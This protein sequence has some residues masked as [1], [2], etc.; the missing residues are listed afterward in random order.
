MQPNDRGK[1]SFLQG[2]VAGVLALALLFAAAPAVMAQ[3]RPPGARTGAD[4]PA[5]SPPPQEPDVPAKLNLAVG[6]LVTVRTTSWL[7]SDHNKQGETFTAIL[8]QPLIID[9]W[10]VARRGQTVVGQVTVSDKGGRVKGTSQ[11]GVEL[12]ELT[13]V[14][15]QQLPVR[16][17][18]LKMTSSTSHGQDVA[19]VVGTTA[20]GA[21]IG[22]AADW[23]RG[24]GIGAGVGAAAGI[25]G[26]L[27]TRGR[28]AVIPAESVL[29]FR[30][31]DPVTISTERSQFAFRP[32]SDSDYGRGN[33]RY[34]RHAPIY[35][36]PYSPYCSYCAPYPY[37]YYP[38]Y[39]Y[40]GPAFVGVF[41]FRGHRRF[42]SW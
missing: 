12:T 34:A 41:G 33:G 13:L 14:D 35:S 18:F 20:L 15:G 30:M 4:R 39:F 29:I 36:R 6:T 16:S 38:G 40:P 21:A 22:A 32:V 11:L 2:I 3:D 7:S 24:A 17:H 5:D 26:V 8:E 9:G 23:G 1:I 19:T 42:R 25:I 28:P 10:V 31:E 37:Y 27:V